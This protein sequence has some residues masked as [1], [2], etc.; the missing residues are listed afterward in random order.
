[1]KLPAQPVKPVQAVAASPGQQ[2]ENYQ[3]KIA[4]LESMLEDQE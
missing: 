3:Q 2:R 4:E 1:M